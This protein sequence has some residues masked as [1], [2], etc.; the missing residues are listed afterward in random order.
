MARLRLGMVGGGAGAFIG[1]VH[2]MASS[3]DGQYQL[4]CGAFSSNPQR[5]VESGQA[6]GYAN[7]H[8]LGIHSQRVILR[9][10]G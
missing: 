9:S 1:E 8:W 5:S 10:Q 3:I 2:R 4:V 7:A 6:L